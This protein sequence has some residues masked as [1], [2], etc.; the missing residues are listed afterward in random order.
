MKSTNMYAIGLTAG[1]KPNSTAATSSANKSNSRPILKGKVISGT[2]RKT[3][4][5]KSLF[6]SPLSNTISGSR[7]TPVRLP[8]CPPTLHFLFS[9]RS[10]I[11]FRLPCSGQ[12]LFP[13][14]LFL[15]SNGQRG[16]P[17]KWSGTCVRS[18]ASASS[19]PE[20]SSARAL[21]MCARMTACSLRFS[22]W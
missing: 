4:Y 21:L 11:V 18:S 22:S 19:P 15:A 20:S 3:Q 1:R 14:V 9:A 6:P 13:P 5:Q 10:C 7:L 2:R 16:L 17:G 8:L 12:I